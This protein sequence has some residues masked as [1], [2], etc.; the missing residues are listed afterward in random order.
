MRYS[1]ASSSTSFQTEIGALKYKLHA[2]L[3]ELLLFEINKIGGCFSFDI[4]TKCVACSP[5]L[6]FI[7]WHVPVSLFLNNFSLMHILQAI[8][9]IE[10]LS[11]IRR[12]IATHSKVRQIQNSNVNLE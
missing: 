4:G 10:L 6:L 7:P 12:L 8:D 9:Q 2:N 3:S 5:F 1:K 11:Y